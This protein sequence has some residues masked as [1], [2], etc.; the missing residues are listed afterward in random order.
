MRKT[1]RLAFLFL[2]LGL[3]GFAACKGAEDGPSEPGVTSTPQEEATLI[4]DATPEATHVWEQ[5]TS[6]IKT[7]TTPTATAAATT[8]ATAAADDKFVARG[9]ALYEK[10]ECGSCHG[11]NAEGMPD[12]GAKLA[13]TALTEAEFK[14]VLRTGGQGELGNDHLYGTSA[15]SESGISAVYAFLQSL[16][17]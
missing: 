15:I 6:V 10:T 12:E 11:A 2:V 4:T 5:P 13:G 8:A 9:Q 16:G 7:D 17:E 1:T 3:L 14:D